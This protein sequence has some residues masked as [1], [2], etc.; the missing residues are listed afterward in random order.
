VQYTSFQIN[1]AVDLK[2]FEKPAS[3]AQSQKP[4]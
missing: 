1:P 2:I 4:R 3:P